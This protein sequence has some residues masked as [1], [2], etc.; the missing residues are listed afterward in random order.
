MSNQH[1]EHPKTAIE[2]IA[3]ERTRQIEAEG[4][5]P[6][7]D[8]EHGDGSLAIA[9]A[10]YALEENTRTYSSQSRIPFLWP[11]HSSWWKPSPDNRVRELVKAGALI[12]AEIERLQRKKDHRAN[13]DCAMYTASLYGSAEAASKAC[14]EHEAQ[15]LVAHAAAIP[16][17]IKSGEQKIVGHRTFWSKDRGYWHEPL[18]AYEAS[19]LWEQ[20]EREREQREA[21]MPDEQAAINVL[22]DAYIRLK[23]LGWNDAVYCPKDG[24][25]FLVVEVGS[26]G[27]HQCVY[28]GAW[29]SGS[30]WVFA[31]GDM[32]PSR[33]TLWKPIPKAQGSNGNAS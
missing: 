13:G 14:V 26:T 18:R 9:A 21:A 33:P 10:A 1:T 32:S 12:V 20:C 11:W 6:Q 7:H 17:P 2:L 8:D 27:K 3:A 25:P 29:P 4:Y 24:R 23:D 22:H 5:T 31:D 28:E 30:W 15:Q 16:E 19:A